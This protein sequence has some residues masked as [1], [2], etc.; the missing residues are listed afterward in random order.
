MDIDPAFFAA[1]LLPALVGSGLWTAL[2]GRSGGIADLPAAIGAGW[3]IGVFAAASC[4]RLVATGDTA[5]AFA[6]AWPWCAGIG[7]CAWTYA[8]VRARKLPAG[9]ALARSTSMLWRVVWLLLLAWIVVRF[10]MI[11]DEASL[12]PVFPWDAWSAWATKPKTWFL[13]GHV[14]PYVPMIEWLANPQA[15]LRTAGAWSYP[16]LL[17]WVQ[18]WFASAAG[19]WNEPLIDIAWCGA[20]VAFA[21]AAYGYW[22]A[23]GLA[24]ALALALVYGLVSLPLVDA[25]VALAGYADLWVA[26]TL[27]LAT[28]AWTR[29]LVMREPGQLVLALAAAFCLPALKLE[30]MVWLTAFGAV[31]VLDLVP[32]RVR[33]LALP[34]IAILIVAGVVAVGGDS[35]EI[36]WNRIDIPSLGSFALAWHGV[37]GAMTASLFT[38][39]NW[40]LLWYLF[41]ILLLL[42]RRRFREDHAASMLGLMLLIDFAFLFVLFFLTTA[43]AWAQDFTSAN[44]LILQLVPSVFVLSAVLL[45]PLPRAGVNSRLSPRSTGPSTPV[46][47]APA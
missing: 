17:A 30:G 42:R 32:R 44:R 35:V 27:G 3:L 11:G 1:W 24:P 15:A 7:A 29:W 19:T 25:H 47:I 26:L 16:E 39:P 41:P 46:P 13:T 34:A 31:V 37:G 12:R 6:L 5:H 40:H 36:S 2:R 45:R 14:E 28:L 18:L 22:R 43:S 4:A 38:L 20:L 8:I 9:P 10:A 21:L 33:W 23:I